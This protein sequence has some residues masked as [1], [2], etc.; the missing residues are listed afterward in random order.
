[1]MQKNQI[2]G[3][4]AITLTR[5][6]IFLISASFILF[7]SFL[8]TNLVNLQI[9]RHEYYKNKVYDQITTTSTLKA[10]RGNIYDA[11]MQLLATDK[12]VYR[13]FASPRAIKDHSKQSGKDT[14][15][16]IAAE[17]SHI[18]GLNEEKI[19]KDLIEEKTEN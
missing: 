7:T 6:R 11:N 18:L 1:M 13:I 9:L 5:K 10:K 14:L 19:K 12:T 4:N 8:I 16:L 15:S 2:K 17:V 3:K